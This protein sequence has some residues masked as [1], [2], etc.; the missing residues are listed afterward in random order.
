MIKN[1]YLPYNQVSIQDIILQ[2][3]FQQWKRMV[4]R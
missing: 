3:A 1:S 2:Y 4:L